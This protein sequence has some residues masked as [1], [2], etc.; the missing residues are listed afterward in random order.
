MCHAADQGDL[1]HQAGGPRQ[2]L[3][4]LHPR[5]R[6]RD[7]L[8]LAPHLGGGVGLRVEGVEVTGPA[9]VEDQ[10]AGP[11]RLTRG[12]RVGADRLGLPEPAQVQAEVAAA[13][14]MEQ[15]TACQDGLGVAHGGSTSFGGFG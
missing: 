4:D 2:V 6:R 10:D 9:V 12:R 15:T 14:E 11:D 13:G 3:A 5:H 7:G 8:E 1:V